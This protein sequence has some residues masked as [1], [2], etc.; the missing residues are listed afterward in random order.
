MDWPINR[1]RRLAQVDGTITYQESTKNPWDDHWKTIIQSQTKEQE[2]YNLY[3]TIRRR[4][5]VSSD[6]LRGLNLTLGDQRVREIRKT[7]ESGLGITRSQLQR[8]FHDVCLIACLPKI[9]KECWNE[10]SARVMAEFNIK[11]IKTQVLA[12]CPRR[13]GKSW[14]IASFILALLLHVPG[15]RICVFS[16][17]KRASGNLQE[18]LLQLLSN[19][20]DESMNRIIRNTT[21]QL[22]IAS[23]SSVDGGVKFTLNSA[24]ELYNSKNTSKLLSYPSAVDGKQR[25]N[26]HSQTQKQKQHYNPLK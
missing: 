24:K 14:A 3:S 2:N 20:G 10:E 9:Y 7:L 5:D 19:S 23:P 13:F 26:T 17:G 16:T 1:K 4:C 8:E 15:I 25:K 6:R 11:S 18:I 12:C 21:E 22:Y